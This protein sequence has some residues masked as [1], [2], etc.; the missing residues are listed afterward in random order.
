MFSKRDLW[1]LVTIAM[2]YA[3]VCFKAASPYRLFPSD[4]TTY[5]NTAYS[6]LWHPNPKPVYLGSVNLTKE[7]VEP[8]GGSALTAI[9]LQSVLANTALLIVL[10]LVLMR[11]GLSLWFQVLTLLI[12]VSSPW[13]QV[14]HVMA[15]YA[16]TAALTCLLML[17]ALIEYRLSIDAKKACWWLFGSGLMSS[18][19]LLSSSS[20]PLVIGLVM[21]LLFAEQAMKRF[22]VGWSPWILFGLPALLAVIPYLLIVPMDWFTANLE[23]IHYRDI[24]RKMGWRPEPPAFLP[25]QTFYLYAPM[26]MLSL[27]VV[28]ALLICFWSK[29][30]WPKNNMSLYCAVWMFLALFFG[31]Q[32]LMPFTKMG[33]MQYSLFAFVLILF[34]WSFYKLASIWPKSG[35]AAFAFVSLMSIGW[36][37]HESQHFLKQRQALPH[38]LTES[39]EGYK[40]YVMRPDPHFAHIAGWLRELGVEAVTSIYHFNDIKKKSRQPVALIVGPT[41]KNSG[42]SILYHCSFNDFD[43]DLDHVA[44]TLGLKVVKEPYYSGSP[45]LM[46]EEEVCHYLM[47]PHEA[48]ISLVF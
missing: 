33:R 5:S 3:V 39:Y 20:A 28:G 17:Y 22:E 1:V 29:V 41:G 44:S 46:P 11:L 21:I 32:E 2:V 47:R 42:M 6:Q 36:G 37:L 31:L 30:K 23:S 10:G 45:Y 40:L 19:Y 14:Y 13:P 18:L 12:F 15:G 43:L 27:P 34:A 48:Q 24:A 25:V 7:L 4:D 26:V 16:P 8:F 35:A 9:L 38:L